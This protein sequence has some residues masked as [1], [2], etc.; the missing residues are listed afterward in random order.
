MFILFWL[1]F[2]YLIVGGIIYYIYGEGFNCIFD[3]PQ[4][5]KWFGIDEIVIH[6][7][8]DDY[9][10]SLSNKKIEWSMLENNYYKEYGLHMLSDLDEHRL[11]YAAKRPVVFRTVQGPHTYDMLGSRRVR[12]MFQYVPIQT[13]SGIRREKY[14][15]DEDSDEFNNCA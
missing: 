9:I 4:V 2:I 15:I 12:R 13:P 10:D 3:L 14:I 8:L 1:Y 6:E 5:K 7:N 11:V